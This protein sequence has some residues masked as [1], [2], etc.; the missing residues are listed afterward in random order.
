MGVELLYN[1]LFIVRFCC[2]YEGSP[3]CISLPRLSDLFPS[4]SQPIHP[5]D[6]RARSWPSR[7][8]SGSPRAVCFTLSVLRVVCTCQ[9]HPPPAPR[10]PTHQEVYF[11]RNH[12]TICVP[13]YTFPN[14]WNS[15]FS[16]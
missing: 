7:T 5:G 3:L 16:Q 12:L 1:V 6:R 4:R 2:A 8:Y 11:I 14:L 10:V 13:W 15:R 9:S